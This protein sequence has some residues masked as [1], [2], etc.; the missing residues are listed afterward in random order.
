MFVLKYKKVIW[1]SGQAWVCKTFYDGSNPSV[2]SLSCYLWQAIVRGVYV[3][4]PQFYF[5]DELNLIS[6]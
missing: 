5:Y 2:T 3:Y 4:T 6:F 1:P